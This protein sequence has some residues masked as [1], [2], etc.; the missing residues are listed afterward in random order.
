[1]ETWMTMASVEV[2]FWLLVIAAAA[3][4]GGYPVVVALLAAVRRRPVARRPWTPA[5]SI[6]VPAHNEESVI[7]ETLRVLLASD[8]PA[9][10]LEILVV[11]DGSTDATEAIVEAVGDRRVRL[12]RT[13]RRVGKAAAVNLAVAAARGEVL[14]FADAN[15]RFRPDTVARLVENLADP[16]VGYVTGRLRFTNA[17]GSAISASNAAYLAFENRLR[18]WETRVGSVIGVNGGVEAMHRAL[19]RPVRPDLLIDFVVPC[20]VVTAGRRVVYDPRAVAEETALTRGEQEFRM[21]V[22]VA[23]RALHT[24]WHVRALLNP[25][26]FGIVAVQLALHKGLR[27]L[28][29]WLLP[30]LF[31][32]N[33]ALAP[34]SRLYA[35]TLAAQVVFYGT[36]LA[37]PLARPLPRL[38][39]FLYLPRYFCLLQAASVVALARLAAGQ[40]QVIW[41]PRLG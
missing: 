13:G 15:S 31:L 9:V 34:G 6:V 18:I 21:R 11:S 20:D 38:F 1:M 23:M 4:T 26:R 8:Y 30:V 3:G 24:L 29:G 37:A 39:Q 28:V 33:L 36:A 12:L 14:V 40:R 2:L 27:Y 17:R 16:T 5:V 35:W 22:R 10:Q 32:L 25:F 41:Q 7:A 19:Y